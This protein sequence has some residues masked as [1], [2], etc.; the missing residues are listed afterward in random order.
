[1]IRKAFIMTLKPGN[2]AE[3]KH[4]HAP[5]WPQLQST[6]F[7]HGVRNYSIFLHPDG[8]QLFAYAEIE[9]E[10]RWAA[11]SQTEVCQRWWVAMA[12]LMDVNDDSSPIS[13]ECEEVFHIDN[14]NK[15]ASCC[16]DNLPVPHAAAAAAAAST[17]VD[18]DAERFV[19]Q[20][21]NKPMP[22]I[23]SQYDVAAR[24][25]T[26]VNDDRDHQRFQELERAETEARLVYIE[27][28][29]QGQAPASR[30]IGTQTMVDGDAERF[31]AMKEQKQHKKLPSYT[32]QTD[33][34]GGR[35]AV[36]KDHMKFL[37]IEMAENA[38]RKQQQVGHPNVPAP[39]RTVGNVRHVSRGADNTT[40]TDIRSTMVGDDAS[41]FDSMTGVL[42]S[43]PR[44]T[45]GQ[46]SISTMVEG[47]GARYAQM[48][49]TA[50]TSTTTNPQQPASISE[51]STSCH[52]SS[53]ETTITNDTST[54]EP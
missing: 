9:N 50:T 26:M 41:R 20:I 44:N 25:G 23:T 31:A 34:T 42:Q 19:S 13:V 46:N 28:Q 29:Q 43:G 27:Q 4:R 12:E 22:T 48:I 37:E 16:K 3:Y 17:M 21:H 36:N 52:G 53:P 11:I 8:L 39:Q 5:I 30:M 33:T 32:S 51:I 7:E 54:T 49:A 38:A 15:E 10:D 1:M 14:L 18:G 2:E 6:L 24:V 45:M 40:D 47:D 35:M